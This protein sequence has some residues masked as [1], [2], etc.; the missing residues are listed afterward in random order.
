MVI[1]QIKQWLTARANAA[2][3][4]P[5]SD[6]AAERDTLADLVVKTMEMYA[7]GLGDLVT[8]VVQVSWDDADEVIAAIDR[9]GEGSIAAR[10]REANCLQCYCMMAQLQR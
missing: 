4:R 2:K 6:W 8:N 7:P 5:L 3:W 1:K 10:Q 9:I